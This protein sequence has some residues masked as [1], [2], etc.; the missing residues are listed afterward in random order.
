MI[1]GDEGASGQGINLKALK[2]YYKSITLGEHSSEEI[3][4]IKS[5]CYIMILFDNLLFPESTCNS[6]NFMHLSLSRDINKIEKV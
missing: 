3:K 4:I 2:E 5:K 1:E 6:F